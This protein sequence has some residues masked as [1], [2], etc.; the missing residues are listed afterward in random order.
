MAAARVGLAYRWRHGRWPRLA[1]P[2]RFTEWVQWRK[3]HDRDC[4]RARLTDKAHA[5]RVAA[6]ALGDAFIIPTLWQGRSLPV[7]A[8]WPMPF[9]VKANHG[10]GQ[11]LVV[12]NE[13][14]YRVARE[15]TPRWLKRYYGIWL[16]EW[17]YR[18][19]ERSI[20]VEPLIGPADALPVDYKL[21]VFGGRAVMVQVHR[22][23]GTDHVWCQYGRDWSPLSQN[24]GADAPPH[25]LGA[26]LAAAECLGEGDDFIRVDFYEVGGQPLFGEF[27]LYPGSGLDPFDPPSLDDWLGAQWSAE[28][29][30]RGETQRAAPRRGFLAAS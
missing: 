2:R 22:G 29:A 10:C 9:I 26:M 15:V 12:R 25:G 8:P 20:L 24:A 14:E 7:A 6:A 5:K 28:R 30:V 1:D 21:Y 19:A 13:S 11:W 18:G 3:L 23:R 27:C 17:H 16:D 4:D